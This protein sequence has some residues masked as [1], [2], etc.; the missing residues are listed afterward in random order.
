MPPGRPVMLHASLRILGLGRDGAGMLCSAVLRHVE[1]DGSALLVP[2]FTYACEDPAAWL[3]P[4]VPADR[5]AACQAATPTFDPATTPVDT[6]LGHLPEHVRRLPGAKRSSHPV[7][8]FLAVGPRAAEATASQPLDLPLGPDSALGWLYRHDGVVVA[9]GT[10]IKTMTVLHLA[11]TLAPVSAVRA[12]R[13]RVRSAEGWVWYW[14]APACAEGFPAAAAALDGA[15]LNQGL[16]GGALTRLVAVRKLV[17]EVVRGL[18]ADP[19]WLLCED[20]ACPYCNLAR[21][22]LD[23]EIEAIVSGDERAG[24]YAPAVL[25]PQPLSPPTYRSYLGR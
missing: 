3:A 7:L 8:S 10:G 19:A 9:A 16:L 5:L 23:G 15:T 25:R 11:E 18:R 20:P 17:D 2:A 24:D 4:P 12:T 22:Y 21:R 6:A 13:R 1:T 14:G